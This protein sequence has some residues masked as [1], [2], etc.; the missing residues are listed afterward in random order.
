LHPA[1]RKRVPLASGAASRGQKAESC[2]IW[3]LRPRAQRCECFPQIE[4]HIIDTMPKKPV[5]LHISHLL[6]RLLTA[7]IAVTSGIFSITVNLFV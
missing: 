6:Q 7:F 1:N 2:H 4:K 3:I 5:R